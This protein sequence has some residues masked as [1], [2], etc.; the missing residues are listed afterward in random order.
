MNDRLVRKIDVSDGLITSLTNAHE[1]KS[2]YSKYK[3]A[4]EAISKMDEPSL[5]GSIKAKEPNDFTAG[6][7]NS[8]VE[9]KLQTNTLRP[10][11]SMGMQKGKGQSTSIIRPIAVDNDS[12]SREQSK[13]IGKAGAGTSPVGTLESAEFKSGPG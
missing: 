2:K 12:K 8:I 1:I 3:S 10:N 7:E 9:T 11:P 13:I 6:T 5:R 4:K